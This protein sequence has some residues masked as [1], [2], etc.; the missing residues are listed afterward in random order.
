MKKFRRFLNN[1][2]S[3]ILSIA[4]GI[5]VISSTILA[6][7]A[8]P[9]AVKLIEEEAQS[10]AETSKM[11]ADNVGYEFTVV[12]DLTFKEK[13]ETAWKVYIPTGLSV[14][15]T[16]LCIFGSE[17]LNRRTQK[18]LI[19]AYGLLANSY[20]E[21]VN[22]TKEIFGDDEQKVRA[23]ITKSAYNEKIADRLN[24]T[25]DI[26]F[27]DYQAG[28]YFNSTFSK[29]KEA[30]SKLNEEYAASGY[31]TVNDFYRFLG[32]KTLSYG[33]RIG[34]YD[35]GK[36]NEIRFRFEKTVLDDDTYEGESGLECYIMIC[37]EDYSSAYDLL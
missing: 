18:S 12:P 29:I 13:V 8:T 5:G 1:N 6:V 16:L 34:W 23:A 11:Y 32:K 7:K 35:D 2:G 17:Y 22:K 24:S 37:D 4:S 31:V 15:A 26:L 19:A 9:K 33:D 20:N 27:F 30:E 25:D 21:Y 3:I 14:C 28:H 36:Y 10:R